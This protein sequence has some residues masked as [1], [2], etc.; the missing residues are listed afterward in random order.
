M[1]SRAATSSPPHKAPGEVA[2]LFGLSPI[3]FIAAA[4]LLIRTA[5]IAAFVPARPAS[6]SDPMEALRYECNFSIR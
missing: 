6:S 2:S 4:L 1:L 5:A 3:L